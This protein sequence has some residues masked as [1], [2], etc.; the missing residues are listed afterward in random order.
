MTFS[1]ATCFPKP[2]WA[3]TALAHVL[4][5]NRQQVLPLHSRNHPPALKCSR[6]LGCNRGDVIVQ[7]QVTRS[8]GTCWHSP[9]PH[10]TF[11][12]IVV[13]KVPQVDPLH[14]QTCLK[15]SRW[16]NKRKSAYS[17]WITNRKETIF[18]QLRAP[19]CFVVIS[20]TQ[21]MIGWKKP[22]H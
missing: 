10:A 11:G 1:A 4:L 21:I 16:E 17:T 6:C 14:F 22:L 18:R 5:S 8:P 9:V 2:E 20:K 15:D 3:N 13:E 7:M 19:T 12:V